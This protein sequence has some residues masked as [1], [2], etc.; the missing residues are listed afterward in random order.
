MLLCANVVVV[1]K[2]CLPWDLRR[3]LEPLLEQWLHLTGR[4]LP[5]V[6]EPVRPSNSIAGLNTV[7]LGLGKDPAT[8]NRIIWSPLR[9]TIPTAL[10][11]LLFDI[12]TSLAARVPPQ[13][14]PQHN[15]QNGKQRDDQEHNPVANKIGHT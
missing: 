4:L 1:G 12:P 8:C 15:E 7:D 3:V 2:R 5:L 13:P 10:V 9:S 6:R 11:Q 14:H